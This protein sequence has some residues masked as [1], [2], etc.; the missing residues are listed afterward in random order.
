MGSVRLKEVDENYW[1]IEEGKEGFR[2]FLA[3]VGFKRTFNNCSVVIR[4]TNAI[5]RYSVFYSDGI[6][7]LDFDCERDLVIVGKIE[8]CNNIDSSALKIM[9]ETFLDKEFSKL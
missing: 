2:K 9:V 5:K 1:D 4:D 8:V 7:H 3:T 6:V